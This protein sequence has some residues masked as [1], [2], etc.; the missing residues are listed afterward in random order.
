MLARA[1]LDAVIFDVGGVLFDWHPR[2]LYA[3]LID[4]PEELERFLAEVVTLDWHFQHDA[5]RRFADTSA[6]LIAR[7]PQHRALIEAY[8][9]RWLETVPGPI[10]GMIE[11]VDEL[12]EARV[13]LY[14]ITN[15]SAEFWPRFTAQEPVFRHFA[16]VIVSGEH[17][18]V[19]PDAAIFALAK[20]RF[21]VA[22]DRALFVDD[23]A[24]N[25]M[26]AEAA[27]YLG[28]HFANV[29][30]LRARLGLA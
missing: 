27:G 29:A 7:H 30:G 18:I 22:P 16:D 14:A 25:V 11:L 23:R 12:A 10:A 26:A 2:N 20:R 21:P 1:G 3:R 19:K 13:P 17:A 9:P 5:G 4:D 15:F 28:H 6:E 8:G 24:E